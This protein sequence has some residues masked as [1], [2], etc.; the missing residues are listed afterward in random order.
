MQSRLMKHITKASDVGKLGSIYGSSAARPQ[1][2]GAREA[3]VRE[4][5]AKEQQQMD[6]IIRAPVDS[7]HDKLVGI[8]A[9]LCAEVAAA[10]DENKE[11]AACLSRLCIQAR[12]WEVTQDRVSKESGD[13]ERALAVSTRASLLP[14]WLN[15]LRELEKREREAVDVELAALLEEYRYLQDTRRSM[16]QR[17]DSALTEQRQHTASIQSGQEKLAKFN[18]H[19]MGVNEPLDRAEDD[20]LYY[21][22]QLEDARLELLRL[23]GL[24]DFEL[25]LT[26]LLNAIAEAE[27]GVKHLRCRL[28][29]ERRAL[30]LAEYS[31]DLLSE[32]I[33]SARE[34]G[35]L[36][37]C[38]SRIDDTRRDIIRL[39][40]ELSLPP[41]HAAI[42]EV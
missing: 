10:A 33:S 38:R 39:R 13:K 36:E 15:F 9:Q 35:V 21:F 42:Y 18:S 1:T 30:E 4:S 25:H 34:D 32:K 16:K 14:P 7:E 23:Q 41:S 6:K 11:L 28:A 27:E 8:Y 29:D 12:K 20:K 19:A 40:V 17:I 31:R 3:T 37:K 22:K 24:E 2:S 5:D 26:P